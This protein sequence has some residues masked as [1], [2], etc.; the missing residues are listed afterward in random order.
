MHAVMGGVLDKLGAK[1]TW[2]YFPDTA[3]DLS[4]L[5]TKVKTINPAALI[6]STGDPIKAG[7]LY[8]ALRQSGWEGQTFG[9][10]T[11]NPMMLTAVCPIEFLEGD[12]SGAWPFYFNDPPTQAARDYKAAYIAK[13]GKYEGSDG[14]DA[15]YA[16][17]TTAIKKAGSLDPDKIMAV[18]TNGMKYE[19]GAGDFKMVSRPDL[20]NDRTVDSVVGLCFSQLQN[21]K[22]K[23]LTTISL[24][25][26]IGYL[27]A[28]YGDVK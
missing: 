26:A 21:G 10:G 24:D 1:T 17:L 14:I 22:Q 18:I 27:R 16:C 19:C 5:A 11:G 3:Q 25:E 13:Y 15:I 6:P 12:I 28:V 9:T 2:I 4:S 7:L 23:V 8:K 20:G